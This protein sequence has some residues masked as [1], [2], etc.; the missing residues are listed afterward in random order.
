MSRTPMFR[1]TGAVAMNLKSGIGSRAGLSSILCAAALALSACGGGG[2][3]GGDGPTPTPAPTPGSTTI[4]PTNANAVMQA[5]EVKV[6][7]FEGQLGDGNIPAQTAQDPKVESVRAETPASNGSTAQV[8][9]TINA[10]QALQA[11]F[12][13]VPGSN[14][15]ITV[16]L[17]GAGKAALLDQQAAFAANGNPKAEQTFNVEVTLPTNL[18][19]G[20][21]NV[22]IAVQ[23]AAGNVSNTGRGTIVVGRV[24]TGKLQFSLAWDADVDLDLHVTEP[25][26]NEIFWA[27]PE[28]PTGGTLDI[29]DLNGPASSGRP[30]GEPEG[31]ENIFW[32]DTAPTGTYVVR[33]N[34]FDSSG[35]A[36]NFVVTVSADGQVLETISRGNFQ[37]QNGCVRVYTLNY[38][39]SAGSSQGT[40]SPGLSPD[41][42]NNCGF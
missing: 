36:A 24:G 5:L 8:P 38:G 12:L 28:S 19:Q 37:T 20:Q 23:D 30:A 21:F 41:P 14:S 7:G 13:K 39:G 25:N 11:L 34:Y 26:G 10:S 2:G 42:T 15:L 17:G 9:I 1:N 33:V 40:V 32:Q 31:V 27:N 4:S 29:D 6:G 16:N 18:E 3:G 35:P 22:D